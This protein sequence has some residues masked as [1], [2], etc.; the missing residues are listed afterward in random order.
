[1]IIDEVP[2]GPTRGGSSRRPHKRAP[3]QQGFIYISDGSEQE[4][5]GEEEVPK[6]AKKARKRPA[7]K[8]VSDDETDD[9]LR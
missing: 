8:P 5:E 7:K 3:Q 1:M 9:E 6:P 2:A 4:E